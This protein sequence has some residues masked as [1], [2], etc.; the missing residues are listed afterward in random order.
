MERL[1]AALRETVAISFDDVSIRGVATWIEDQLKVNVEF[2]KVALDE[3]SVSPEDTIT[4]SANQISVDAALHHM[5]RPLNLAHLVTPNLLIITSEVA[6]E[7]HLTTRI[8]P[9]WDLVMTTQAAGESSADYQTLLEVV[10]STIAPSSWSK[11]GGAGRLTPYKGLLAVSQTEALHIETA[12]LLAALRTF[13]PASEIDLKTETVRA[14][15]PPSDPVRR[16][17]ESAL[18]APVPRFDFQEVPLAEVARS[19]EN[20]LGIPVIAD[21]VGLEDESVDWTTELVSTSVNDLTL[22]NALL[23][24]LR[25]L[26]LTY[27]Y[28]H[29]ALV[30]T[31][32]EVASETLVT[33]V[34]QVASLLDHSTSASPAQ[35]GAELDQLQNTISATVSPDSWDDVGGPGSMTSFASRC[36]LVIS[37]TE[38][39]HEQ[40]EQL[41]TALAKARSSQLAAPQQPPRDPLEP[42]VEV[43]GLNDVFADDPSVQKRLVGLIQRLLVDSD[44]AANGGVESGYT[45]EILADRLVVAHRPAVQV[46]IRGL[47]RKLGVLRGDRFEQSEFAGSEESGGMF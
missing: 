45:M 12:N 26:N 15:G 21:R 44:L 6:A 9:V 33:K 17:V 38:P 23:L 19:I 34:Y 2:D 46:Q 43:Y 16:K 1:R 29:E 47:L 42:V 22:G 35:A 28:A 37:Q 18:A 40:V 31:S 25:D 4:F 32:A 14:V 5:L 27:V 39:V 41:I 8:Y 30:I 24:V 20:D 13:P 10:T 7:A 36:V 3:E 11:Y